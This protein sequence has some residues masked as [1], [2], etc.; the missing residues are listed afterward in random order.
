MS[1]ATVIGLGILVW[2]LLAIML[3]LFIG[4]MIKLRD[5]QYP[6]RTENGLKHPSVRS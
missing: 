5:R 6:D 1:T 3:S 4:R 2:V